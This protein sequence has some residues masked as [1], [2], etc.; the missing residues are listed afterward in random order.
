MK[1]ETKQ[2]QTI[3]EFSSDLMDAYLALVG[4][5]IGKAARVY[6]RSLCERYAQE[7]R[8]PTMIDL[9]DRFGPIEDWICRS[10]NDPLK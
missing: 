5:T 7:K 4:A 8:L 3:L 9:I 10:D 2:L 1:K 6:C